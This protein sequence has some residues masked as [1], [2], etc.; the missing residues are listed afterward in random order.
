[1]ASETLLVESSTSFCLVGE[2]FDLF[3]A[4]LVVGSTSFGF[5]GVRLKNF[6]VSLV[7]G[8][9]SFSLID[10]G[11]DTFQL[12]WWRARFRPPLMVKGFT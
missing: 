8:S 9:T 3:T 7:E 5:T 1:M 12:H 10:G 4:L 11:F 2:T 6:S